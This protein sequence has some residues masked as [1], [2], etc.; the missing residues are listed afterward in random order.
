MFFEFVINQSNLI[1]K[2]QFGFFPNFYIF[3]NIIKFSIEF[4]HLLTKRLSDLV[5]KFIFILSSFNALVD[6]NFFESKLVVEESNY[7]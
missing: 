6:L 4:Y 5:L 1:L 2:R 7:V 3:V